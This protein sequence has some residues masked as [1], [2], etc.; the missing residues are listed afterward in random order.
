MGGG[1]L[2]NGWNIPSHLCSFHVRQDGHISGSGVLQAWKTPTRGLVLHPRPSP[3]WISPA[4]PRHPQPL[5]HRHV[6]STATHHPVRSEHVALLDR[7]HLHPVP[8]HLRSLRTHHRVRQPYR[9]LNGHLE[10][11]PLTPFLYL[12]L[13]QPFY[14]SSLAW[15]CAR[16]RR[17]PPLLRHSKA[18]E[19]REGKDLLGQ[20]VLVKRALNL[21]GRTFSFE[22]KASGET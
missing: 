11:V 18:L 15:Y 2:D 14:H 3:P 20:T 9:H 12:V 5:E 22:P 21:G 13:Q 19:Q 1:V 6:L 16:L 7:Q 4:G 8:L 10:E 17:H